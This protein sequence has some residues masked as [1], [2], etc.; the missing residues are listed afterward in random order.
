MLNELWEKYKE[1]EV[2]LSVFPEEI[3]KQGKVIQYSKRETIVSRGDFPKYL[4]FIKSGKTVGSREYADGNAYHYFQL[5]QSNGNIGLLE[6]LSQKDAYIATIMSVTE[7]EVLRIA[8][9]IIYAY[10]MESPKMLRRCITFVSNDLYM[11]S[12]KDGILYYLDG[13]NRLRYYLIQYY[14]KHKE[15]KEKV[16]V[17]EEYQDIARQIGTSIRTVGRGIKKL[18][19]NK[20]IVSVNK[21]CIL[22]DE[23]QQIMFQKLWS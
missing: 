7:V 19:D 12:G 11:S 9:D 20:E 14:E 6:I 2:N 1:S 23:K 18:K 8:S 17:M 13:I 3:R 22:T 16:V 5:D 15:G 10:I 4:Y 21:K